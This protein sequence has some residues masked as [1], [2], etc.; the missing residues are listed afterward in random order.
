MQLV[1]REQVV[2]NVEDNLNCKPSTEASQ[3]LTKVLIVDDSKTNLL[4]FEKALQVLDVTIFMAR[5]GIEAI[6]M[7]QNEAPDI[8]LMDVVMPRMDGLEATRQ[9]KRLCGERWVP[10]IIITGNYSTDEVISGLEAG[11]EDYL[12]KPVFFPIL[13]TKVTNLIRA[14]QQQKLIQRQLS[15]LQAYQNIAEEENE[16]AMY[17]MKKLLRP[18]DAKIAQS[19]V[20]PAT[21]FSGDAI[22][23]G[24]SPNGTL[25]LLLADGTGHGLA[26]AL[27]VM[28]VV[29]VFYGMNEKGLSISKI[30]RELNRKIR[31]LMPTGRFVAAALIS[32]DREKGAIQVWNG[33][34]PFV[35]AFDINRN[36]LHQW[37]STHP[38]LG[39]MFDDDF[40]ETVETFSLGNN[41]FIFACSDGLLEAVNIHNEP[42][43]DERLIQW[44]KEGPLNTMAAYLINKVRDYIGDTAMQDDIS[45]LLVPFNQQHVL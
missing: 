36:V 29:E 2:I 10:I 44:I 16:L 13:Q 40:E 32:V 27:N 38:A 20:V 43:G 12:V 30:S 42:V 28:P 25:Q 9:I 5:D 37:K 21:N 22:V 8:V 26:A 4:L 19:L 7:F 23:G 18:I 1:T 34:M 39:L 41:G 14:V 24:M 11:A 35:A 45:V 33:S 6:E 15:I 17:I 3:S 31:T